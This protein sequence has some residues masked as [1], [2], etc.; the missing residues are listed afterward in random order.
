MT[1]AIDIE[2]YSFVNLIL[3]LVFS[4]SFILQ[5]LYWVL[6]QAGILSWKSQKTGPRPS[7]V[8]IIICAKNEED[9]LRTNL[10]LILE[11]EY[12]EFEVLVVDDASSDGTGE[13]LREMKTRYPHL[14]STSIMDNVH[15]RQGKKLALTI[16][17]KGASHDWVLLTDADCRPAGK[18]WLKSM[19]RNFSKDCQ[20]V[21]G[22]GKYETQKGLLNLV[23]RSE[24][25]LTALQYIGFATAGL[26]YMGVGRNLAYRKSLFFN[27]RGFASHYKLASGDDD[28]FIN[29]VAR[30]KNTKIEIRPESFTISSPEIRW[31][32]WYYQKKRHLTTGPRY[33]L[34]TRFLLGGEL[35]I[36]MLFYISLILL[37]LRSI[38][39]PYLLILATIRLI[40]SGVIIKL[41]TDRLNEKLLLLTSLLL[42]FTLPWLQAF[43]VFSN[44]VAT[45]RD[46][47][48]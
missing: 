15:I 8:S 22:I 19:Q 45:K 43:I 7:P 13:V 41:A 27:N 14:R 3:I 23:I 11:Q 40:I 12:P 10:P 20:I 37:L 36:R 17:I 48:K 29:E 32:D 30:K 2:S 33:R 47:W 31:K 26:P 34:L 28:L 42:D 21:L 35:A 9:N 4:V 24:T 46:R 6:I 5:I 39:L 25:L 16:G 38:L 1:W 44:Y 18:K